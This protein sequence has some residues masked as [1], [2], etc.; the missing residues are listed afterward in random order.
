MAG[1]NPQEDNLDYT[2]PDG[3]YQEKTLDYLSSIITNTGGVAT[4]TASIVNKFGYNIDIDTATPEVIASFGGAFDPSTAV[5]S[6]AQTFTIAYN[7]TTDGSGGTGA[8]MLQIDYIDENFAAA[9]AFHTLGGTGSDVTAFT[10]VGINRVVVVS[11]GGA[12]YNANDITL[13]A[14]TDAT[15][16]AR[17]PAEKSVTQQAIYHTPI[18]RTLNVNFL[19]ISTLKLTGG[20]GSPTV[21]IVGYSYSRVT[22]GRYA[23]FDIEVDTSIENNLTY[24]FAEAI[25]FQG[26]EVIYFEA[27]T[28]INNTKVSLRFSGV[29]TDS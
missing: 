9:S 15:I 24:N 5:I 3:S 10:G 26:R 13:T 17:V 4:G 27:S 8:R 1:H 22:G 18:N 2:A 29:E 28:D 16:Q 20:G 25:T 12:I 23:V 21:N 14:T 6:T 11:L 7:N 19:K